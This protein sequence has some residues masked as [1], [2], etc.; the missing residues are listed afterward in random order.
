MDLRLPTDLLPRTDAEPASAKRAQ[1]ERDV[2]QA[3]DDLLRGGARWN[4]L[5]IERIAT[6][7]GISRTAFYFYF[8]DKRE[9]LMRLVVG[10]SDEV[11]KAS[12]WFSQP[13]DTDDPDLLRQALLFVRDVFTAHGELLRAVVEVSAVDEQVATFFR[14]L[15][16]TFAQ[17]TAE[18]A[19]ALRDAKRARPIEPADVTGSALM[20]MTEKTFYEWQVRGTEVSDAHIDALAEVWRR[21]IYG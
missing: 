5:S 9:L 21:A 7:A 14:D 1:I 19:L 8:R 4:D 6:A 12:V 15:Q 17:L 2:L 16:A 13:P 3:V 18:R 20:A 10:V 11:M